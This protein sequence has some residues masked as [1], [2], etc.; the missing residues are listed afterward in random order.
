VSAV[1]C[2]AQRNRGSRLVQV[3]ATTQ[4]RRA[5][6]RIKRRALMRIRGQVAPERLVRQGLK[7]GRAVYVAET[8]YLDASHPWLIEIGDETLVG[9]GVTVLAHDTSTRLHT[10]HTLIGRVRIG[11]RVYLGHGVIVMPGANIGDEAVITPGSVVH[12]DVPARS[13][14]MGNPARVV[15][16]VGTFAAEHRAAIAHN[17]VWPI[18]GWT[19]GR[20]ITEDRRSA[21]REALADRCGYLESPAEPD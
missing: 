14:A 3:N 8:A 15:S 9:P 19:A 4:T 21:Q 1:A 13:L 10:D 5:V 11:A 17:P 6:S 12:G 18:P 2:A 20:G 16:D 7:L